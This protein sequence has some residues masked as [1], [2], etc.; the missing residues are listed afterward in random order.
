MSCRGIGNCSGSHAHTAERGSLT[1]S[2]SFVRRVL[3]LGSARTLALRGIPGAAFESGTSRRL[4]FAQR[5]V[6]HFDVRVVGSSD[7]ESARKRKPGHPTTARWLAGRQASLVE[8]DSQ[9]RNGGGPQLFPC[10]S[11]IVPR[12][13]AAG[14]FWVAVMA[15]TLVGVSLSGLV[16]AWMRL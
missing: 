7:R 11:R 13:G 9:P 15:R 1:A 6:L 14:P 16:V 8:E 10:R 4:A 5:L 3:H 12:V 2:R